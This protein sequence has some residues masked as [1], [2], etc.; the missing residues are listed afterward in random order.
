MWLTDISIKRPLFISMLLLFFILIGAVSYTRLGADQ[1]PQVNIPYV[2]VVVPYP[3]AG[4]E[5]VESSVTK[6]IEDAVAGVGQLKTLSSYSMDGLS[7]VT[8][9]FNVGADTDTAAI[10]VERKV[11]AIRSQLPDEAQAPSVIKAEFN[12]M[13]ILSVSLSSNRPDSNLYHL[14]NDRLKARL[15]AVSGV[16]SVRVVGGRD[17]EILVKVDQ[18][19]LRAR[20]LSIQ[21]V[22]GALSQS[23]I[24]MPGGSIDEKNTQYSVRY[25]ALFQKPEDLR[26]LVLYSGPNGIVYLRDVA[27][28]VDGFKKQTIVN[29]TNGV[30]SVG[31]LI[32]KSSNANTMQVAAALRK[33]LG[34]IEKTL[35]PDAKLTIASDTSIF[36]RQSL[37][38]IQDS[39]F[40][41]V[42][43]TGLVLL[44]F[45]HTTRSTIIVLF[46]IPTSL[47]ST[48]LVMW[49]MGFTLNM[50]SMMALALSIGIL[51]DDSIVV[52][53]NIFRHLK[54]GETPWSA[55]LKG[56]SEIGL[57]AIAI[58][59]VDVVVYLPMA[60]MTG[61]VGQFFRQFG[62]TVTVATLFSL[63]VSFTLTPM[64]ASRWLK[65]DSE[66]N[67][68]SLL[69][70][71]GVKWEAGYDRLASAYRGLLKGALGH[72]KTVIAVS[73]VAFFGAVSLIPL[74]LIG[75]EFLPPEDQGEVHLIAELPPG[76][77]LSVTNDVALRLESRLAKI[78]EV[79]SYF[80]TVGLASSGFFTAGESRFARITVKIVE[81]SKRKKSI[82]EMTKELQAV[83]NGIP[84]LELRAQLPAIGG[85]P[86]QPFLVQLR[87]DD[88]AKLK[89]T[90]AQITEVVKRIPG[91]SDVTNSAAK[92][93]PEIRVEADQ[94]RLADLGLT[95]AQ[96]AT[97]LR[98]NIEGLVVSQLRPEGQNKVDIRVV[99][100]D[101]DRATVADLGSL[102]IA[103]PKGLIARMDQAA[104][105]KSGE[106]PAEI[107]RINRQLVVTVGANVL[108]RPLGDV[109]NDFQVQMASIQLP[110]G[111]SINLGSQTE[112][113]DESFT[114]LVGA[115]FLSILLMYMLM[116]A[117]YESLLYPLII[118]FALP[119]SIVGALLGLF[120]SGQSLNISSM[121]G[122]IMLMGL[123]GKNG[124]LLVDYT[125]TLRNKGMS[126]FDAIVEAGPTR[127]R[128]ILMTTSAMVMAM[129]PVA[130][131]S[132]QGAETR[133]PMAIVV[134][135]GLLSSTLLTLVLVP[136]VY[137]VLDDLQ[138]R[139]GKLLRRR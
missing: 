139:I 72:R 96:V 55:A 101:V 78:P 28:I 65:A 48:F 64:L 106:S 135:G 13:P 80:T 18:A 46:S 75:T 35:P 59:L 41:A 76:T 38:D 6:V 129:I 15:E 44:L 119:V 107:E 11:S 74:K 111:F 39:L 43:L 16:A 5:E 69:G 137:T 134:I 60:F 40:Y 118:M 61:M 103:S 87:G 102:P 2:M 22:Y 19:E 131:T 120:V 121:I 123:V 29:R 56:R 1:Y 14:A 84:G 125:N 88:P 33:T 73:F 8:L 89:S 94:Q 3:G 26:D 90:A 117:L 25:N 36:V 99:G 20:G 62:L 130:M 105:M 42:L 116:V 4:P 86:R 115:L 91:T 71:F 23:N 100:S 98:A 83:G 54:L 34:N 21:Q 104:K 81:K 63:F 47:I 85:D 17:R 112:L 79:T 58:T 97:A 127:L 93:G 50:M 30:D 126:R 24:S 138:M 124:I 109:V 108:G 49:I 95:S 66:D 68:G 82:V 133:S 113:M 110:P 12:A 52:L 122:M 92:G 132:G 27:E 114:S 51:V 57:A 77:P 53:E 45:L 128:P 31:L 67:H 32:T 37:N 9:E 136:V 70:R 10:D 7:A